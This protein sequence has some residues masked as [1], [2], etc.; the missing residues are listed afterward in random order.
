MS[1]APRIPIPDPLPT[2]NLD[3]GNYVIDDAG[4][5][6]H[7]PAVAWW[8]ENRNLRGVY[9]DQ[10]PRGGRAYVATLD[11]VKL[12]LKGITGIREP[13]SQEDEGADWGAARLLGEGSYGI[14]GLG[15]R[16]DEE[17]NVF[18][19]VV[20]KQE[21]RRNPANEDDTYAHEVPGHRGLHTEALIQ[22]DLN[23]LPNSGTINHSYDFIWNTNT[24]T[25]RMYMIYCPHQDL[26]MLQEKLGLCDQFIPEL[27][28]FSVFVSLLE[29]A[30]VLESDPSAS[31][32]PAALPVDPV[33]GFQPFCLHFDLKLGNIF[34]DHPRSGEEMWDI[35][36]TIRVADFGLAQYTPEMDPNNPLNQLWRC[37]PYWKPPETIYWKTIDKRR[38]NNQTAHPWNGNPDPNVNANDPG[39][40]RAYAA[41]PN[42]AGKPLGTSENVWCI[43]KQMFD[44][45][46][47]F[48][49]NTC[50]ELMDVVLEDE[51][52]ARGEHFFVREKPIH[53]CLHVV[54]QSDNKYNSAY[55]AFEYSDELQALTRECL[56]PA[57]DDRPATA[58]I[59]A[60]VRAARKAY[61]DNLRAEF[62]DDEDGLEEALRLWY[63]KNEA[64]RMSRGDAE[65]L[66][67]GAGNLSRMRTYDDPD[68]PAFMPPGDKIEGLDRRDERAKMVMGRGGRLYY[69]DTV[70]EAREKA[71]VGEEQREAN[72]P[73]RT[74]DD[75]LRASDQDLLDEV[76]RRLNW[77]AE[78]RQALEARPLGDGKYALVDFVMGDNTY[79]LSPPRPDTEMI[80]PYAS[81]PER[82]PTTASD[83]TSSSNSSR[84]SSS[85]SSSQSSSS[86][87][88]NWSDGS[89]GGQAGLNGAPPRRSTRNV[90]RPSKYGK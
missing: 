21:N 79:D 58:D 18:H 14:V 73:P 83:P 55:N 59:L 6:Q 40:D 56:K 69:G 32:I 30:L 87:G 65:F 76:A 35:Y 45:T 39:L 25:Y 42:Q 38:Q 67:Y 22:R 27:F 41:P 90:G 8:Q 3:D 63:R 54:A 13:S 37:T 24:N 64:S 7:A 82:E 72:R 53:H 51:Y 84:H 74:R 47:M 5:R 62:E 57:A 60:R 19:E 52:R 66:Q 4:W 86:T 16:R 75:W 71:R 36:P 44:L 12:F 15:Q 1:A 49:Y 48:T 34:L 50:Q 89:E 17:G 23:R 31:T 11:R 29:A 70:A 46:S 68:W 26:S 88:S 85:S 28:L 77:D 2:P 81:D 20:I 9:E 10:R 61:A 43:G 78:A 80:D 33:G